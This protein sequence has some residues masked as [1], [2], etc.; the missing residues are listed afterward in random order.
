M[1]IPTLN[2][3]QITFIDLATHTSG[4]PRLPDGIPK[5][6]DNPYASYT[7]D[8]LYAFLS[9]HVLRFEPGSHYA[10][11]NLG[12][13]L[14]GHVLALRAHT[15]YEDL[16]MARVCAPLGLTDTRITL[17]SQWRRLAQGHD[18]ILKP[19]SNWDLP[20]LAGAGALRSTSND[21]L[22]FMKATCL[23]EADAPLRPAIDML[24]QT[25]RPAYD[26][27]EKAALGWFARMGNNDERSGRMAKPAGMPPSLGFLRECDLERWSYPTRQMSSMTLG[28]I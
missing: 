5:F 8:Q 1:K 23:S 11:S 9:K 16:V 15:N 3:R 28:L 12:F 24:L 14:L 18:S 2:G 26:A 7:V 10:Y 13:G 20:T 27:S 17:T 6:G 22:K 25:R 21:L 19:A 4:L